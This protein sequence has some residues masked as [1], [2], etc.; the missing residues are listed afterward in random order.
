MQEIGPDPVRWCGFTAPYR[1]GGGFEY[2]LPALRTSSLAYYL[3]LI[4]HEPS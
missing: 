1:G 2:R 4:I 3:T